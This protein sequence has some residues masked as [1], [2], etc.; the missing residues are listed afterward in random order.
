MRLLL[1][2][3]AE[4]VLAKIS[5]EIPPDRVDVVVVILRVVVFEQERRPLDP[6]IM[7]L[8]LLNP[9]RPGKQDFTLAGLSDLS[10]I[11]LR[12]LRADSFD[13]FLNQ[14]HQEAALAAVE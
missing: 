6:I 5:L 3:L 8:S 2:M 13:I 7:T 1:V 14:L 12:Q 11:L 9:S 4:Q 10:Q